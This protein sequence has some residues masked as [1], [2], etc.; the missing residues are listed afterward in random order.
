MISMESEKA[1]QGI[2]EPV[3]ILKSLIQNHDL[4]SDFICK[5]LSRFL[6]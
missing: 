4:F 6:S 3:R 2:A 1:L 5:Y